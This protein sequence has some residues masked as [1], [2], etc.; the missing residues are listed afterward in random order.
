MTSMR[1]KSVL[2][3]GFALL[4]FLTVLLLSRQSLVSQL[5]ISILYAITIIVQ[6]VFL[7]IDDEL[8]AAHAFI[9]G[10]LF[11]SL[12]YLV[13][14]LMG[15]A[16]LSTFFL[17][18]LY[19]L[20]FLVAIVLILV[21][22]WK[23]YTMFDKMFTVKHGKRTKS[24]IPVES[25]IDEPPHFRLKNDDEGEW[26][27]LQL[28]PENNKAKKYT[29]KKATKRAKKTSRKKTAKIARKNVAKKIRR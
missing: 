29:S 16:T 7:L 2:I 28:K 26:V 8:S 9:T 23:Q 18:A 22:D 5:T 17:G 25:L 4:I 20:L 27:E 13:I 1:H 14:N 10:V 19:I 21:Y 12:A 11:T 6:L 24:M 15:S 3:A